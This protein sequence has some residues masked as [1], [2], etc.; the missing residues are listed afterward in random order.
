[1][2]VFLSYSSADRKLA[3]QLREELGSQGLSVWS[4]H[5]IPAG[6]SWQD[7]L[8]D[9]IR[10]ADSILVLVGPKSGTDEAQQ[11]TWRTSLETVW[12]NSDKRL[13]PILLR[14][15]EL[16]PFLSGRNS[17]RI[18]DPDPQAVGKVAQAVAKLVQGNP[19]LEKKWKSGT[20]ATPP[21]PYDPAA[22]IMKD[23]GPPDREGR[24]SEIRDYVERLR[25]SS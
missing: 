2:N 14:G 16:P 17:V 8:E 21:P 4:D 24:L 10:S 20:D 6:T 12:Q 13:I 25:S 15:A 11:F 1:M 19:T 18:D 7:R 22:I 3:E 23:P 9:A 5:L